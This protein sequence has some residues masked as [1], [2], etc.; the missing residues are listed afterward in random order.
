MKFRM[1]QGWRWLGVL[2][3][4]FVPAI[5]MGA[6]ELPFT[7]KSGGAI[8]ASEVN[9]NFAALA[10]KFDALSGG[11][12]VN[13]PI[14][15]FTLDT[16]VTDAPILKFSQSVDIPWTAGGPAAK[17]Q[18]SP[19]VIERDSGEGSPVIEHALSM[20]KGLA[21]ASIVLGNLTIDLTKVNVMGVSATT[22]RGARAQEAISLSF[23]TIT[24]TW[25]EPNK[26]VRTMTYDLAKN[27]GGT[28]LI[29]AFNY[30]YFPA[31]V[32]P[33]AAYV[34]ISSFA[35]QI[36]TPSLGAKPQFGTLSI[37][38]GVGADTLDTFGLAV[39][40]KSGSTVDVDFFADA[41]TI[42]NGVQ[43]E[44][45]VVSSFALSTDASGAVSE[46]TSFGYQT[47]NWTAGNVSQGWDIVANKSL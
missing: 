39:S 31:G 2:G 33:D 41:T 28:G 29:Q 35:H 42:N 37:V 14:G 4:V 46:K 43:L 15:T 36:V 8:K 22:P 30:G 18:F 24:Y 12:G 3:A 10:A 32:A 45:V 5:V 21:S 47:I 44:G 13:A 25:A 11:G 1:Q 7:F 19:V 27:V 6:L 9:A 34:P 16:V 40:G 38:K 20:G 23:A 17:A 26:P